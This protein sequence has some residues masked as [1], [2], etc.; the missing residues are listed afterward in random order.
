[1]ENENQIN[2]FE[3]LKNLRIGKGISLE[4][5]AERSRIQIKYLQALEKG[6]LIKI[7]E[8][9]DK[10]FFKSYLKAIE[11][12]NEEYFDRFIKFRS[13]LRIDKTTAVIQVNK[14]HDHNQKKILNHRNLFVILP[15][16]LIILAV[17]LLLINTEMVGTSSEG[18]VQ[19]IDIVNV[20]DRIQAQEQAKL[21]SIEHVLAHIDSSGLAM[22]IGALHKTWFRV[23]TDKRDTTEYLL[24]RGQ[25]LEIIADSLLEFLI[26]RADGLR[27]S[28][29]GRDLGVPSK[30]SVVVRYMRIDS[31]GI[32][33]KIL[34]QPE[35]NN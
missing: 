19:E 2:L 28:L 10:L 8:V 17:V 31:S 6:D 13:A 9:Y 11:S 29:N 26:G 25:N 35:N 4:T 5:V 21:D 16:T 14:T 12:E 23:V 22:T 34:K 33:I 24:R 18:K 3:E 15:F 1:M 32:V 27:L 30:D 20:V 7:P